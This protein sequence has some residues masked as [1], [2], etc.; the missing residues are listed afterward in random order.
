MNISSILRTTGGKASGNLNL[1]EKDIQELIID[2]RKVS[3]ADLAAFF[4]LKG[5]LR[6]GHIFLEQAY[7]KGIR[8]LIVDSPV[9][10]NNFPEALII[11]VE[12]TLTALQQIGKKHRESFEYPVVGITGSN[13]KTIVKEWLYELLSHIAPFNQQAGPVR[14][15]KSYNSQIG[16][17]LSTW[18]M[19]EGNTIGIFEAGIS[20]PGEMKNAAEIIQP[21]IGIFTNIGEAHN[22]GF[23]TIE[24]KIEEKLILFSQAKQLIYCKDDPRLHSAIQNWNLAPENSNKPIELFTW[25]MNEAATLEIKNVDT[26]QALTIITAIFKGNEISISIPYSDKAYLENAIHCWACLLLLDVNPLTIN[27]F[28]KD[29]QPVAMRLQ[30]VEGINNCTLINDTYN[31]D[32]TSLKIALDFLIQQKTQEKNTLILSD[33]LELRQNDEAFYSKVAQLLAQKGIDRLIAIGP[34]LSLYKEQFKKSSTYSSNFYENTAEFLSKFEPKDFKE[35]AILLKGARIFEFEKIEDILEAK[36]H[37]TVLEVDLSAIQNNL[38]VYK[39]LL[40]PKVK[41]MAMVKA[42]AYGTG[43]SE[44]ANILQFEGVDYLTVAYLDEG[45]SLRKAGIT[46]PIMVMSPEFGAFE[47]MISWKIE[48]EIFSLASLTEF[49]KVAEKLETQAY[50]IHVKLDTGMHRLGFEEAEISTLIQTL[51]STRTIQLK[52]VFSHLAGSDEAFFDGFTAQQAQ[53]FK[54][55]SQQILDALPYQPLRHLCN[56]SAIS[57]FPE[58]HFDMVRL[59]I[60]IYGVDANAAVQKKLENVATLKTTVAQVRNVKAGETVGYSRKGV[61]SRDSKVATVSIGYADGYFRDFGN[62]NGKMLIADK[63]VPTIGSI[64]M[65]MCMLDVTHIHEIKHGDKVIV[66]GKDLPITTLAKWANT[67]PYE[68]ITSVSQRVKRIYMNES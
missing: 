28:M 19:Q 36:T 18:L 48:P 10:K 15:P 42:F 30:L 45:I 44:I 35:E 51:N 50:P 7:A 46:L 37:K 52:S 1:M 6:D 56:S 49:L 20:Q 4:A 38:R 62:G 57:R 12:N 2:T 47:Q 63:A 26:S 39:N 54:R 40:Q 53:A 22:E 3:N 32:Y 29:L 68:I 66:F 65:D 21:S 67:I 17:P 60:G 13:G 41:V 23:E 34:K 14:S 31:S 8:C 33:I 55:M 58:F 25:S 16:I 27:L 61:L 59:G 9:E 43:S 11:T 64:C 5:S 24:Q